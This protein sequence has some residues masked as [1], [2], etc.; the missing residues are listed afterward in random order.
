MQSVMLD[1]RTAKLLES[2]SQSKK[3]S[4]EQAIATLL[5]EVTQRQS[6]QE[7]LSTH[8]TEHS[9]SDAGFE[10]EIAEIIKQ[11]RAKQRQQTGR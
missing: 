9:E 10:A 6:F 4:A 2:Y 7:A 8:W 3:L 11:D 5:E 1:D